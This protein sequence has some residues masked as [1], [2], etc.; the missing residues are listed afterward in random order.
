MD[1]LELT[2]TE[3]VYIDKANDVS[4]MLQEIRSSLPAELCKN[5]L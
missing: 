4:K 3:L 5:V 1:N 2:V